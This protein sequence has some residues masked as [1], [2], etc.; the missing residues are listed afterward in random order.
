[1]AIWLDHMSCVCLVSMC[2]LKILSHLHCQ[3]QIRSFLCSTLSPEV[4]TRGLFRFSCYS[5]YVAIAL[6][7]FNSWILWC[8]YIVTPLCV[9]RNFSQALLTVCTFL[10]FSSSLLLF[11]KFSYSSL[12]SLEN[13]L[14]ILNT[15]FI[16]C[17]YCW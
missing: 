1:M 13:A 10:W 5:V 15:F 16:I 17:I 7:S 6:G 2:S 12:L 11:L 8:Q 4:I 14:Y 3:Q 9:F